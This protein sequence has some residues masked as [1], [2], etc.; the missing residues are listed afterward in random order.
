MII[1]GGV[2][3]MDDRIQRKHSISIQERNKIMITGVIDVFSFDDIQV[4]IETNKGMLLLQGEDL[5]ITRLSLD[6]GDVELEGFIKSI[7]YHEDHIGKQGTS[8]FGKLFK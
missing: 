7:I 4:D 5:H 1:M 6:K 8:F 2:Y 3:T